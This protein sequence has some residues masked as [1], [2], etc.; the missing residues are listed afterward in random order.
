MENWTQ[1]NLVPVIVSGGRGERNLGTRLEEERGTWE[2]GWKRRE[3]PG[4]EVGR[5]ER[6]LGTRLGKNVGGKTVHA[7]AHAPMFAPCF[8]REF[9]IM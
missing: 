7:I 9:L 5:G 8:F 2:R 6:N 4:N 3:E 1:T